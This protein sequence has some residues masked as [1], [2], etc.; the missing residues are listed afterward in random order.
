MSPPWQGGWNCMI[1]E[2]SFNSNHSMNLC[3]CDF[4]C[5]IFNVIT[6]DLLRSRRFLKNSGPDSKLFSFHK[7]IYNSPKGIKMLTKF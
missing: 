2:V 4:T 1:F 3:F 6:E 5:N 7:I